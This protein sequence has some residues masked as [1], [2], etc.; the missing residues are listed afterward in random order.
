[1]SLDSA[2]DYL[3]SKT[4]AH[5]KLSAQS[6]AIADWSLPSRDSRHPFIRDAEPHECE[7]YAINEDDFV[8]E[9]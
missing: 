8:S 6:K 9:R 4:H 3:L 2:I 5:A 1:M 7:L